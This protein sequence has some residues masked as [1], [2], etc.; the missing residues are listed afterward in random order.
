MG[1]ES[2]GEGGNRGEGQAGKALVAKVKSVL[3]PRKTN[4]WFLSRGLT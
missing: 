1:G 3:S 2:D 4:G